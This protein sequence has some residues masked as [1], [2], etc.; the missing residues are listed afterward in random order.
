MFPVLVRIVPCHSARWLSVIHMAAVEHMLRVLSL[1][2]EMR[3]APRCGHHAGSQTFE[4]VHSFSGRVG[5]T[6][7]DYSGLNWYTVVYISACLF[8]FSLQR[9]LEYY[10]WMFYPHVFMCLICIPGGHR[11]HRGYQILY[12]WI[13]RLLSV[14][15]GFWGLS[16][17]Y[18]VKTTSSLS[19]QA[20]PLAPETWSFEICFPSIVQGEWKTLIY[21]DLTFLVKDWSDQGIVWANTESDWIP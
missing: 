5:L 1:L 17:C 14:L 9:K 18:S 15:L 7:Q 19:S 16:L 2:T 21:T 12:N 10:V 13:Y 8:F 20:I 6:V 11:D 3:L 4:W